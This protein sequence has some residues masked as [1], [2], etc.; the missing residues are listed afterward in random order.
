M[1]G[2]LTGMGGASFD[3][4]TVCAGSQ[5]TVRGKVRPRGR[6]RDRDTEALHQHEIAAPPHH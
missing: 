6:N 2:P 3:K 4:V 5:M 1:P